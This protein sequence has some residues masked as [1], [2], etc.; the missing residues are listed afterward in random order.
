MNISYQ[1]AEFNG[2]SFVFRFEDGQFINIDLSSYFP[3]YKLPNSNLASPLWHFTAIKNNG[4]ND[5]KIGDIKLFERDKVRKSNTL[6]IR[7]TYNNVSYRKSTQTEL[8]KYESTLK[9]ISDNG[10]LYLF[11]KNII[12]KNDNNI[13]NDNIK[14]NIIRS[15]RKPYLETQV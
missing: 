13:K 6:G 1:L 15:V 2:N 8:D 12:D 5:V 11:I 9:P 14:N 10:K 7:Y 3:N 4:N